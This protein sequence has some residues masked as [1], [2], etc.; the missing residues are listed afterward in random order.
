MK[1]FNLFILMLFINSF[2]YS[3][4]L[5][6][7]W[8]CGLDGT[9][10]PITNYS[11]K[12]YHTPVLGQPFKILIVYVR[13]ANDNAIPI[14][15]D[16]WL[17]PNVK[18]TNPNGLPLLA[19]QD[20]PYNQDFMNMYPEYTISDYFCEMSMG[21]FDVVGEEIMVNLE[22]DDTFYKDNYG[23]RAALNHHILEEY[24]DNDI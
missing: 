15:D 18:P 9:N 21:K 4:Q 20:V 13:F 8:K 2:I 24:V 6:Y 1:C 12:P 23:N 22:E 14:Y 17:P 11:W 7:N 16:F 5:P 3:Q 10:L 19:S